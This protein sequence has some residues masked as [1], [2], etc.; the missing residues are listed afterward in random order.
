MTFPGLLST[1]RTPPRI[2]ERATHI[3]ILINRRTM[4][5]R[6]HLWFIHLRRESPRFIVVL[7]HFNWM[8]W[9]IR[10]VFFQCIMYFHVL[11]SFG[12]SL[13][14][15]FL[16]YF[17][18]FMHGVLFLRHIL[19]CFYLQSLQLFSKRSLLAIH[20]FPKFSNFLFE[21]VLQLCTYILNNS[22]LTYLGVW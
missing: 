10:V 20:I 21:V 3:L 15:E 14:L 1:T 12:L 4:S 7:K 17:F 19:N 5:R 11:K 6:P 13:H 2:I 8:D 9:F 18:D 22:S 16:F